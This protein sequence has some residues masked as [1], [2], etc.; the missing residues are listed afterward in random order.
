MRCIHRSSNSLVTII[1]DILDFS[2]I[3][4]GKL[5]IESSPFLLQAILSDT[6]KMLSFSSE[7]KG[8]RFVETSNFNYA[9]PLLGDGGR[10][11]QVLVNLLSNA[12]KFTPS[13]GSISL[14]T[15]T[16]KE[17]HEEMTIRCEIDDDGVGVSEKT[18]SKLFNPFTQAESSTARRYG[19]TGLGLAICKNLV[20]LM[21][22][23]IGLESKSGKGTRAWVSACFY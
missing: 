9:G 11:R 5:E 3:E 4:A 8:L 2:K 14:N 17:D 15:F 16:L 19:G 7:K 21:N 10:I 12:I 1:N 6:K 23:R 13:G 20:L 22:G 18:L